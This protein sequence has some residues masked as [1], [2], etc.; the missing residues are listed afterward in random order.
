MDAKTLYDDLA[1][2]LCQ[3]AGVE[4]STMM[5]FPCLRH[6]GDFFASWDPNAHRLIVKVPAERVDELIASGIV[7]AFVP[8]GR[9]FKEW[10]AIPEA[11]EH[12]WRPLLDE[13]RTFVSTR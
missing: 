6:D 8:N 12:T 7:V 11:N 3:A 4:P 13:A 2:E 10:A 9:R 5:G 1:D